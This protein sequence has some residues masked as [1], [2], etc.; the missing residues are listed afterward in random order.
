MTASLHRVHPWK[1]A[2]SFLLAGAGASGF[3]AC[4]SSDEPGTK[5]DREDAQ[6][7]PDYE[8]GTSLDAS[9]GGC[10][11][12]MGCGPVDCTT[13]DF[14]PVELPVSR[15]VALT[16]IWGSGPNDIWA[17]GTRGTVLH[18]DGTAF[19]PVTADAIASGDVQVAVWGSSSS[20][21]WI[22]GPSYPLHSGGYRDGGVVLER[23]P[24]ASWDPSKITTGRIWAGVSTG[25]QVW[26]AGEAS[27]RFGTTSSFWSLG[28]NDAGAA[29]WNPLPACE[30]SESCV[31]A[32]RALWAAD[33]SSLWAVGR[34]GQAF[35][36]DGV[37]SSD[38]GPARWRAQNTNTRDDLDGVW[39][40]GPNDVWAV[41]QHGTIR[42]GSRESSTWSSMGSSTE[43]DLHAVWGSGPND[44]W[45]VGDDGAIVHFD[46]T[47][48][49]R[50]TLGLP[51]GDQAPHLLGVW[52][53]G[54]DDVWIVGEGI[55]LH[56]TPASRRHS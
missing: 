19:V 39:G 14:C 56:R 52:G 43:S 10:S 3:I 46:G 42:H 33:A 11:D 26:L 4:A 36:F 17:V 53:S 23:Y 25:A 29:V 37:A 20:D 55:L 24:G 45:A 1:L 44:V 12:A 30:P 47:A 9:D 21:V 28:A 38:G 16:A 34:G 41:G 31:P 35:V 22:L 50:A 8:A 2:A 15:L 48:W 13:V 49:T 7:L 51:Q 5:D 54:P 32:V 27:A 18:S 6:T 40:S